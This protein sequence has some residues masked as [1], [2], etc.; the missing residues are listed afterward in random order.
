MTNLKTFLLSAGLMLVPSAASAATSSA[1]T[2][3]LWV[4][5]VIAGTFAAVFVIL[6]LVALLMT[7]RA[8]AAGGGWTLGDALSE[9]ADLTDAQGTP[10]KVMKASSSRLIAF[11]GLVVILLLYLGVGAVVL[12]DLALNLQLPKQMDEVMK[13]LLSGVVLFAPYAVNQ[14]RS[15]MDS[16]GGA[17]SMPAPAGMAPAQKN[18]PAASPDP[19][20][21]PASQG[22]AGGC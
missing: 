20:A 14:I 21:K 1:G 7:R 4:Q 8:L 17:I 13:F 16:L 2:A 3:P 11:M 6:A 9:E 18:A 15:A 12:F 22:A 19:G 10:I 5:E